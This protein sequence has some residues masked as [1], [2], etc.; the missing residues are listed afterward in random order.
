MTARILAD[1]LV[2]LHFLFVAFVVAG[3][4][5]TWR[6]RRVAWIHIP[7]AV[8]GALIEFA[9]WICPLTPLEND[10]R[11][12][13]GGAG[14]TGGFIEHYIIPLVYPAG[15]TRGVQITLGI[16]VIVINV[17][18]YGGLIGRRRRG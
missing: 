15:L 10:L 5:V 17:I 14:Y 12:A 8:W 1:V 6:W 2:G 7:V 3:G 18:A 16:A 13:A 9:G 4:F 11:R